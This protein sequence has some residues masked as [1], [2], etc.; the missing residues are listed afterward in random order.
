MI[1]AGVLF[2]AK[3]TGKFLFLK[4]RTTRTA[5]AWGIPGG[6]INEG[7]TLAEG[8]TR[9]CVEEMG[10]M[11][12]GA[13]LIPLHQFVHNNFTYHTFCCVLADEFEPTL[14]TEHSAHLWSTPDQIAVLHPELRNTLNIDYVQLKIC[15]MVTQ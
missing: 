11:P 12:A 8:I 4:R 7:E 3:S 2:Y 1:A 9:E 5:G 6:K 13:R 10:M 14:N 15:A